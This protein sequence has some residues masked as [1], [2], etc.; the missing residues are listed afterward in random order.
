LRARAFVFLCIYCLLWSNLLMQPNDPPFP[1]DDKEYPLVLGESL[2]NL[3]IKYHTLQYFQQKPTTID[4]ESDGSLQYEPN[5]KIN[6]EYRHKTN[7]DQHVLVTGSFKKSKN[8]LEYVLIFDGTKFTMERL[9][10]TATAMRAQRDY[11]P[12]PTKI[13]LPSRGTKRQAEDFIFE[14]EPHKKYK[15]EDAASSEDDLFSEDDNSD[16][17][18]SSVPSHQTFGQKGLPELGPEVQI[19]EISTT[20]QKGLADLAKEASL[21][22]P[23]VNNGVPES[24]PGI[25][26]NS[27]LDNCSSASSSDSE[28]ESESDS[29]TSDSSSSIDDSFSSSD[30]D[31][32]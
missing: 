9:T 25:Q 6:A 20:G 8:N 11:K 14:E 21:S 26:F 5:G 31:S 2:Y 1:E 18:D 30:S 15:A 29:D 17:D 13:H 16:F 4:D 7:P 10:G 3:S 22:Q 23:T 24:L 32:D 12:K 19:E 27:F 28:S